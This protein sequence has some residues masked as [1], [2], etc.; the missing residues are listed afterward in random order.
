[1]AEYN[2]AST[3]FWANTLPSAVTVVSSLFWSSM[4]DWIPCA[5]AMT[6]EEHVP[7]AAGEADV[8]FEEPLPLP[9]PPLAAG[10]VVDE[11]AGWAGDAASLRVGVPTSSRSMNRA[12][13]ERERAARKRRRRVGVC[14]LT[15]SLG[16]YIQVSFFEGSID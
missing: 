3:G 6:A 10:F 9:F 4:L 16:E 8:E 5:S 11:A 15:S 7:P 1:V 13:A 12:G 2:V 14:I